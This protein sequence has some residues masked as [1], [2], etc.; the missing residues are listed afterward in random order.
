MAASISDLDASLTELVADVT[1]LATAVTAN[2]AAIA[3]LLAKIAATAGTPDF[4]P[5]IAQ[6]TAA[7][8]AVKDAVAAITAVDAPPPAV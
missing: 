4:S 5:E 1:A 3:A 7:D 2:S 8:Q 6:V